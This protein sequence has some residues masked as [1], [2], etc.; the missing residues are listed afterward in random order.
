MNTNSA[1]SMC[2]VWIIV[3]AAQERHSTTRGSQKDVIGTAS[4]DDPRLIQP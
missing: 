1:S 4:A 3:G 2:H